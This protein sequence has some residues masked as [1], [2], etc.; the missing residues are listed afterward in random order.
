MLT[1]F[2]ARAITFLGVAPASSATI[3]GKARA[4]ASKSASE[5]DG[6]TVPMDSKI[7]WGEANV[8]ESIVTGESVPVQRKKNYAKRQDE[9]Y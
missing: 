6:E 9:K 4:A 2:G 7:L 8:N 1:S 5:I 3:D